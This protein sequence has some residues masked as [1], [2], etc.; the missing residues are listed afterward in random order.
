MAE[1]NKENPSNIYDNL[2]ILVNDFIDY[3]KE[4]ILGKYMR[5]G[6]DFLNFLHEKYFDSQSDYFEAL[7]SIEKSINNSI[8]HKL[9]DEFE[10]F[11][12]YSH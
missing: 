2:D 7:Q 10:K 3:K 5:K 8:K 1:Y 12:K 4:V 11:W 9:M 6:H